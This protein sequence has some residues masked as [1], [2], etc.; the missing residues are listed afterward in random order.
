MN[1]VTRNHPEYHSKIMEWDFFYNSYE[2]G[3]NY[4]HLYLKKNLKENEPDFKQRLARAYRV[5]HSKRCVNII[6]SYLYKEPPQRIYQN[7]TLEKFYANVDGKGNDIN[8]FSKYAS[9]WASVFG[10]VYICMDKAVLPDIA[11]TGTQLD[12]LFNQ[13]YIYTVFPT[14]VPD[15]AFDEYGNI[16]WIIIVEH[17]RD[18]DDPFNSL[19]D[20]KKNYRLWTK[21]EMFLFD[22]NGSQ[23]D[24]V[25]HGLGVVPVFPLDN[26]TGN[27][28][29]GKSLISDIAYIDRA[30]F[31]NCSRLDCIIADQTFSQLI[32]PIEA[33]IF[34]EI[35]VDEEQRANFYTLATNRVLLYSAAA[36]VKPEYIAPDASQAQTIT[37]V[38]NQ[39]TKQLYASIGTKAGYE[40]GVQPQS[41]ASKAYDIDELNK[42][43]KAKSANLEK[44]EKWVVGM[45]GRWMDI[46]IECDVQYPQEFD[47]RSLADDL[48]LASELV[49]LDIGPTFNTEVLREVAAKVLDRTEPS[50]LQKIFAEIEERQNK[51]EEMMEAD[52]VEFDPLE[53]SPINKKKNVIRDS[54]NQSRA[55]VD[56][57]L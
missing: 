25:E 8:Q 15:V 14:N 35:F 19:G 29:C 31:E 48:V 23:I 46:S 7:N 33:G 41:G 32:F 37:S 26:E 22:E 30:I 10:R 57:A 56:K 1:I 17:V 34:N 39:Q 40:D 49:L 28:F 54:L 21:E 5:N 18:D 50:T 36:E 38:I 55:I 12:N 42:M 4:K 11:I 2:G 20:F 24:H 51:K 53:E 16:K 13:P 27:D 9:Q 44:L 47:L 43:L 52:E 6:N 45:F 3:D